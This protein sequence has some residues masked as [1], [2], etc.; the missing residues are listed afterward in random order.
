MLLTAT[1][2]SG[3]IAAVFE[4]GVDTKHANLPFIK[5]LWKA[6]GYSF[7]GCTTHPAS[8]FGKAVGRE[9]HPLHHKKKWALLSSFLCQAATTCNDLVQKVPSRRVHPGVPPN[10]GCR[11][12]GWVDPAWMP[13]AH[14]SCSV[15]APPQAG[16]RKYNKRLVG[17]DKDRERSFSNYC[18]RQNRLREKLM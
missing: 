10:V 15:T 14:Q 5:I 4:V 11:L 1:G 16:E 3:W 18:H 13:G 2:D 7:C 6:K 8:T 9:G 17:R 12:P